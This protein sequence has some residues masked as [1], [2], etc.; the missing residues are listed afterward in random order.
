MPAVSDRPA[1]ADRTARRKIP[2]RRI[3]FII[4]TSACAMA[5]TREQCFVPG[6]WGTY[7]SAMIPGLWLAEGGQS[8]AGAATDFLLR[9]HPAYAAAMA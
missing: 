8:A 5:V 3:A 9:L 1:A 6:I 2:E 7:F 4:G